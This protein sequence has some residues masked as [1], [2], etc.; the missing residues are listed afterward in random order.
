[1]GL[2]SLVTLL[3]HRQRER[4][5]NAVRRAAWYDKAHTTFSDALV[6]VHTELWK[7]EE[8]TNCGSPQEKDTVQV[9]WA[10]VERLTD[11]VCY[12]A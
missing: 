7:Q 11:V 12:A 4:I 10:L 5:P 8:L 1:M 3:A 2:F 9:P 6:L